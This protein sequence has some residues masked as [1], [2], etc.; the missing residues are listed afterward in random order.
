MFANLSITAALT[1]TSRNQISSPA[2]SVKRTKLSTHLRSNPDHFSEG[3]CNERSFGIIAQTEPIAS[4]SGN[5]K[6]IFERTAQFDAGHLRGSVNSKAWRAKFALKVCGNL[7]S[8]AGEHRGCRQFARN[9]RRQIRAG[10]NRNRV[11]GKDL[12]ENFTHPLA[13]PMFDPF[14]AAK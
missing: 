13:G 10:Q 2:Q 11:F 7:R 9:F 3:A 12:G 5:R 14:D 1:K 8:T 6:N 4:A